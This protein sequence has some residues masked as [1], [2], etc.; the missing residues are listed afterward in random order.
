MNSG[1]LEESQR[2][3]CS[4]Q[5]YMMVIY[6]HSICCCM[7]VTK[8]TEFCWPDSWISFPYTLGLSQD[9]RL[10]WTNTTMLKRGAPTILTPTIPIRWRPEGEFHEVTNAQSSKPS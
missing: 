5:R 10:W 8:S 9:N 4:H 1:S 3:G 2:V 7:V 6:S